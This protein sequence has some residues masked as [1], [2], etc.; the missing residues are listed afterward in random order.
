MAASTQNIM[1]LSEQILQELLLKVKI[2]LQHERSPQFLSSGL[3]TIEY[4]KNANETL[5]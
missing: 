3:L 4:R 2:L 5:R 1:M